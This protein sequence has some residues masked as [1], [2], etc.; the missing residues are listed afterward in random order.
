MTILSNQ[1][2]KGILQSNDAILIKEYYNC[3]G[4]VLRGSDYQELTDF[5]D[6]RN[7]KLQERIAAI[8]QKYAGKTIVI[9]TGDDHYPYLHEYLKKQKVAVLQPY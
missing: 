1:P 4:L 9:L 8:I 6:K 7:Q 3:L 5:Y 2:L